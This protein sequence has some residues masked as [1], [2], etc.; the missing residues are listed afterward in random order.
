MDQEHIG[1]ASKSVK[2]FVLVGDDR[3]VAAIA[4]GRDQRATELGQ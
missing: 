3:L 1:D 4:A 2:C